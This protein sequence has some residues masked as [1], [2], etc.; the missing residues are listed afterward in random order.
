MRFRF[1]LFTVIV[2]LFL[3]NTQYFD[4]P[5]AADAASSPL[6]Q[7]KKTYDVD[8][9]T[10][11]SAVSHLKMVTEQEGVT[12]DSLRAAIDAARMSYKR[13]EYLLEYLDP[14]HTIR[15]INGAPLPKIEPHTTELMVIDPCGLQTLDEMIYLEGRESLDEIKKLAHELYGHVDRQATFQKSS[16]LEH[17]LIIE[18]IRFGVLRVFTLGVTGFDTPGSVHALDEAMISLDAMKSAIDAYSG[19]KDEEARKYVNQLSLLFQQAIQYISTHNNFDTF[20]R[21][22][23]YKEFIDPL[24]AGLYDFHA[25]SHVEMKDEVDRSNTPHNYNSRQIFTEDFFNLSYYTQIANS[26]LENKDVKRLG[27]LLFYDKGLSKDFNMSCASCHDPMKGFSDG[28]AKSLANTPGKTTRRHSPTVINSALY[29]RYF[30]D[31]REYDLERQVKHVATDTLEFN[32]DL[33]DMAD[34]LKQNSE[35]VKLFKDAY[36]NRD[37]YGISSWSIS[38][39]LAVYVAGLTRFDSAFDRYARG[40]VTSYD[41]LAYDGFN[42]FMGK[43]ACGTC[44]F[45]P[46]FNGTVPPFYKD[47]ESEVLGITMGLDTIHPVLDTDLGRYANGRLEE[48]APFYI[49]SMKTVTVRNAGVTAPYM[50]NGSFNTLEEVVQFYNHGGGKGMGL[51]VPHQTLPDSPLGLSQYEVSALVAFMETLTDTVGM[52]QR[53]V[54]VPSF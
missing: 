9:D 37:K 54:D 10:F 5:F 38:N 4:Y 23:F 32:H 27:K 19:M 33:L 21:L 12:E 49:N 11:R 17:R 34:R 40:E 41:S 24:Y 47:S 28:R 31:M 20:D 30:W 16:R 42:L 1:F 48:Q 18:A 29:G 39:A 22:L 44:H 2:V 25:A 50:H 45:A 26:D 46:A 14:E 51:D 36:G 53:P 52:T 35:Y 8:F 6:K 43:A 15:Y 7:I 3:S 13:I